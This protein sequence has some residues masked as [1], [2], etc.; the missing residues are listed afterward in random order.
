MAM[1]NVSVS[2]I[3]LHGQRNM[4]YITFPAEASPAS[5]KQDCAPQKRVRVASRV[6]QQITHL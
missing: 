4:H 5:V 6:G 2:C 1:V 3:P